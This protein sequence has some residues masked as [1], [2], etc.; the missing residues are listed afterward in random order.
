MA[1]IFGIVPAELK[2]DR[3]ARGANCALLVRDRVEWPAVRR[4]ARIEGW[5]CATNDPRRSPEQEPKR[6]VC[7]LGLSTIDGTAEMRY[8]SGQSNRDLANPVNLPSSCFTL[9]LGEIR[10]ANG[11]GVVDGIPM[12]VT[13]RPVDL[14]DRGLFVWDFGSWWNR[15]HGSGR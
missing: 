1:A 9:A 6:V 4:Q 11:R 10:T 14:V 8:G 15:A 13:M 3:P 5:P 12:V 7:V 2:T